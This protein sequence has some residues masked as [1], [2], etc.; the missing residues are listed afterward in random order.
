MKRR[1]LIRWR[2]QWEI[3][4]N[5]IILFSFDCLKILAMVFEFFRKIAWVVLKVIL[6][7]AI[8]AA[9]LYGLWRLVCWLF[10]ILF[11]Q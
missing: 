3:T 4:V 6:E 7:L 2:D 11:G 8:A 9:A 1:V 10:F 5:D